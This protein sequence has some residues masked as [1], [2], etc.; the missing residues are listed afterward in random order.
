MF[1]TFPITGDCFTNKI[2]ANKKK[3]VIQTNTSFIL[4]VFIEYTI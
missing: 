4:I 3:E 1:N 2:K